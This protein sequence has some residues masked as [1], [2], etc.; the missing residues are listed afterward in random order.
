MASLPSK[1][2]IAQQAKLAQHALLDSLV[3]IVV[4]HANG[5]LLDVAGR[6]VNAM[7]DLNAPGLDAREVYQR[8]KS[9]NLLKEN[10]Y[11]FVHLAAAELEKPCARNWPRWCRRWPRRVRR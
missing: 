9:G 11:A 1:Q 5:Q 2:T 8:V 6:M 10:S 3:G 4:K 7:L